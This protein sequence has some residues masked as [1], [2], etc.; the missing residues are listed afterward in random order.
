MRSPTQYRK[1]KTINIFQV[2]WRKFVT[3][4][5]EKYLCFK[6]DGAFVIRSKYPYVKREN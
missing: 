2:L 3:K 5:E 6:S 4:K 1:L